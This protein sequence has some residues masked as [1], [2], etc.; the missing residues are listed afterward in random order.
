M[1][2]LKSWIKLKKY[3]ILTLEGSEI[4][5]ANKQIITQMN[6]LLDIIIFIVITVFL[7]IKLFF[8]LGQK[9]GVI[10]TQEEQSEQ[11]N[12]NT[13]EQDLPPLLQLKKLNPDFTEKNFLE[14]AKI[15]FKM[16]L[17]S[18]ASGDTR[19]LSQLLEIEL[20]K[21][22]AVI[23]NKREEKKYLC[24]IH[25]LAIHNTIIE[26]VDIAENKAFIKVKFTAE[27]IITLLDQNQ[28][29][30]AGHEHKIEDISDSWVFSRD[31]NGSHDDWRLSQLGQVIFET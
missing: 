23:I 2:I 7:L 10:I 19:V 30:I 12:V 8:I 3:L 29:L 17:E 13:P 21:K 11:A 5:S 14:G 26:Q 9:P 1:I 16:I 25:D 15:A 4:K 20:L 18:Y 28:K 31:L 6:F 24:K 22:M 27:A